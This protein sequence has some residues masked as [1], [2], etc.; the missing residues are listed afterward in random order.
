MKARALLLSV[1]ALPF[2]AASLA[3]Q[4]TTPKDLY[5][6]NCKKCHGVLGTPPKA[7]KEKFA[8]IATFDAAFNAKH[9][10]DSIVTVLTKGKGEDMKPFK[11]TL[12]PAEMQIIAKYVK[13]LASRPRGGTE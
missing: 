3:A 11:G 5:D 10:E 9:S 1:A 6:A 4:A 8:K 7:M 2:L 12:T 13:E